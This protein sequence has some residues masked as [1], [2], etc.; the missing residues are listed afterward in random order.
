MVGAVHPRYACCSP[1]GRLH[2]V[3]ASEFGLR[4]REWV[5]V[6]SGQL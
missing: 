2:L 5:F 6:G 1:L 4:R 3:E